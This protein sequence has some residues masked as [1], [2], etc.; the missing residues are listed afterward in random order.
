MKMKDSETI[1]ITALGIDKGKD[2]TR[3][4]TIILE[5]DKVTTFQRDFSAKGIKSETL[6]HSGEPART[7]DSTFVC[8]SWKTS[9][10]TRKMSGRTIE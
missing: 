9:T 6:F 2:V 1:T 3:D 8:I 5:V 4:M 10:S 7:R